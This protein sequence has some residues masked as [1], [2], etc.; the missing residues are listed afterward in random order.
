MRRIIVLLFCFAASA[1]AEMQYTI[2]IASGQAVSSSVT[3]IGVTGLHGGLPVSLQSPAAWTAAD[4]LIEASFDGGTT[5]LPV[6]DSTGARLRITIDAGRAIVL[7]S[8]KLSALP[9]IRLRSVAVAGT[10]DVAQA[11]ERTLVMVVR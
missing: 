11:A 7:D 4:L 3:V 8:G 9:R 10:L 6:Y 5:W 2:T 1:F